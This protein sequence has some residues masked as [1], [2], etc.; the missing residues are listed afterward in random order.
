[1][2]T[3][4]SAP[5]LCRYVPCVT[6]SRG[7]SILMEETAQAI[8]PLD[9][10]VRRRG[11]IG[12]FA[13]PALPETLVRSSLVIVL[14]ELLQHPRQVMSP[15]DQYVIEHLAA[16]CPDPP[17]GERI[18]PRGTIGQAADFDTFASE[19]LVEAATEL[20]VPIPEHGVGGG[21]PAPPLAA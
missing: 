2:A 19:G 6:S 21:V 5:P 18:R 8:T 13:W 9:A 12:R 4:A 11:R 15:K 14:D 20:G 1:M 7:S 16:G 10:A 3:A 17:F